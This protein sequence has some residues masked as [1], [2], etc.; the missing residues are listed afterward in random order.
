LS[1]CPIGAAEGKTAK[2]EEKGA[3]GRHWP[4]FCNECN[5]RKKAEGDV[6]AR[7]R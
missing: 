6:T 1:G 3:A 5:K 7:L 4:P 2:V